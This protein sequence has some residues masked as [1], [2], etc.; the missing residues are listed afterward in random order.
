MTVLA[1]WVLCTALLSRW[2]D[3][4]DVQREPTMV[5][6]LLITADMWSMRAMPCAVGASVL[7]APLLTL[8]A[9]R[10]LSFEH[11]APLL[12]ECFP[13]AGL[14]FASWAA[15]LVGAS[16]G[17]PGNVAMLALWS[18]SFAQ[19]VAGGT[20][21]KVQASLHHRG[22]TRIPAWAVLGTTL[23][24]QLIWSWAY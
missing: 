5:E 22:L 19:A 23:A 16:H 15:A 8:V 7:A 21:A 10:G 13:W 2:L 24:L 9:W 14:S 1:A 11:Q 12:R 4:L 18:G 6:R 3:H 20:A 17:M